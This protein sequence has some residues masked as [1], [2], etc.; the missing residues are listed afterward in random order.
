MTAEE[1]K[2]IA[3]YYLDEVWNK[4]NLA[5]IDEL[6]P[7]DFVQHIGMV[8]QGREGV[9]RFFQMIH[10]AFPDARFT[11]EDMV[12]EGDRVVWRFTITATHQGPF[13]GLPP[14]GKQITMTG[15]N[16]VRMVDGKFAENWGEQDNLGLLQ[17]LG[18]IPSPGQ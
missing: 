17:Q 4:G 12:G 10:G 6:I 5:V 15:M 9:K 7:V 1:N 11:V 8:Q 2:A 3:R 16:I 13:Q 14:T 18:A